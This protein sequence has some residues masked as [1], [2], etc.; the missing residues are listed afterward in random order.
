MSMKIKKLKKLAK[1]SKGLTQKMQ[2][3]KLLSRGKTG[4]AYTPKELGNILGIKSVTAYLSQLKK[5]G[6]VKALRLGKEIYY[7]ST[8]FEKGKIKYKK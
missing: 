6:K 3:M 1:T 7:Y 8:K 2:T 4:R 5:V